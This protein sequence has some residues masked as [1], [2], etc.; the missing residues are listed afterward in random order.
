M[1]DFL[2]ALVFGAIFA[3]PFVALYVENSYFFPFITGKNF[4]FRI[5]VEIGFAAWALLALLDARFRPK[6]SWVLGSFGVLLVVMFFANLF[7]Q[8][9]PSSFF[10]NFERMDGYI[11]LVHVFLYSL[12]LGSVLSTKRLWH[13]FLNTALVAA[14][15]VALYA[16]AQYGG[17]AEGPGRLQSFLGNAAYLA[18]YMLFH[19]FIA[20]WLFVENKNPLARVIYALLAVMFIFVLLETGTRGT[21]VGFATGSLAMVAYIALFGAR[22]KEFR[23]YAL[24]T[25]AILIVGIGGLFVARDSA[26]VQENPNLARF[27]NI[28]LDDLTT[29]ATIWGMAWEGVKDRPVLGWGQSNFNYVFNREYKPE[30][31]DQEQWFDRAHNVFFDWLIAGGFLGLAAYLGIFIASA[32]YLFL[33]PL[34]RPDDTSFDVLERGVLIGVL[35]GYFTHNLVVFDNI[36]SYIF[37]AVILGVIHARVATPIP[38]IEKAR[39]DQAIVTQFAT[40]VALVVV[41]V[42]IY[43]LHVPGMT[44]SA[45]IIDAF[46]ARGN[47]SAQLEAFERAIE[48]DSFAKQEVVE[49]F[50]QRAIGVARSQEVAPEVRQQFVSRAEAELEELVAYKP[51]DAR[52]HVFFASFYRGIGQPEQ[53]REQIAIARELSPQKQSIITQQGV[54]ELATGNYE[55]ATEFF[56]EAYELAPENVEAR[57]FLAASLLYEGR[58]ASAT[59]LADGERVRERFAQ[60]DFLLSAA[61]SAGAYDLLTDLYELRIAASPNSAQNYASLAFVHYQEEN[62]DAAVETLERGRDAIPSFEQAATCF[63]DNIENGRDPQEGC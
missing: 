13:Y 48:A 23:R 63:I 40:P 22:F 42:A 10:S 12:L 14:T 28:S 45:A 26:F 41:G 38:A 53:A 25:L 5:I 9:P 18:I 62:T 60:S 50:A 54:I 24:G 17:L 30:L 44:A 29:R 11:T 34:L 52:I 51:G 4:A 19:I 20:F 47:P 32:Y 37:F 7:G 61:N 15:G 16:L 36:V 1:R 43:T 2:K 8:H 56:R 31:Y 58:V 46:Q 35:V 55:A 39:V 21:F 33:R 27:A 49:Q 59:A 3:V 6:F 57:E